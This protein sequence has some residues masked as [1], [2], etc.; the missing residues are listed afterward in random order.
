MTVALLIALSVIVALLLRK[1]PVAPVEPE[2]PADEPAEDVIEDALTVP[3]Y[4]SGDKHTR[5]IIFGC[6][7]AQVRAATEGDA[8]P[9]TPT[10]KVEMEVGVILPTAI[11][12]LPRRKQGYLCVALDRD[13]GCPVDAN[14]DPVQEP[15]WEDLTDDAK[16]ARLQSRMDESQKDAKQIA[17]QIAALLDRGAAPW[18]VSAR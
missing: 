3:W 10:G 1:G 9:G 12:G 6:L 8:R 5:T 15:A 13:A 4:V 17:V 14:G 2:E 11:H 18:L 16:K 7:Q